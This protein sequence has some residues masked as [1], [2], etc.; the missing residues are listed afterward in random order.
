MISALNELSR[1]CLAEE[2]FPRLESWRHNSSCESD[3]LKG[4]F[5]V[6]SSHRVPWLWKIF[7]CTKTWHH[8][9][10][11]PR[12]SQ[13]HCASTARQSSLEIAY[14]WLV[15]SA[16]RRR[17]QRAKRKWSTTLIP[18]AFSRCGTRIWNQRSKP[19]SVIYIPSQSVRWYLSDFWC[20]VLWVFGCLAISSL[21]MPSPRT[22]AVV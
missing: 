19:R 5:F 12:T 6:A 7:Q 8:R 16:R 22:A 13:S 11:E 18:E 2:T 20:S 15:D 9:R 3:F 10:T 14:L 1:L 17:T 21:P 4:I